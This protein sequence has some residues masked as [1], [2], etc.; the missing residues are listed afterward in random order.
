MVNDN[1]AVREK[2]TRLN[3]D[4]HRGKTVSKLFLFEPLELAL[5]EKQTPWLKHWKR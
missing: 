4:L 3:A 5:I 1:D 2:P